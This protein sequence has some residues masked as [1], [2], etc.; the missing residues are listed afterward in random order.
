MCLRPFPMNDTP[1]DSVVKVVWKSRD[2][3]TLRN[4]RYRYKQR[5]KWALCNLFR[6]IRC[7]SIYPWNKQHVEGE[8]KVSLRTYRHCLCWWFFP[9]IV[10]FKSRVNVKWNKEKEGSLLH[11]KSLHFLHVHCTL[12]FICIFQWMSNFAWFI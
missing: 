5:M 10:F 11:L 7:K 4:R 2:M 8:V 9:G 12:V 6:R 1:S 3:S